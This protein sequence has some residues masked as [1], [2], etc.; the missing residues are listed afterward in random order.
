MSVLE[1][2]AVRYQYINPYVTVEAVKSAD[3]R[4]ERG[5]LYTLQGPSGS[6]KTTLLSLMGGLDLP[7]GGEVLFE[8]QPTQKMKLD[9][10]R[11]EHVSLIYQSYNLLP[12]LTVLENVMYPMELMKV[13]RKTA[14]K[15][16]LAALEQVGLTENEGARFPNMLS[17][18]QQ[19]R[20]AIA[21]ALC[22]KAQVILA[23]EPTGSLD[24]ENGRK[25]MELLSKLA[26]EKGHCVI[27]VTHDDSMAEWADIR[28]AIKDG[29]L[30]GSGG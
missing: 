1:L 20:V 2:K 18:G 30:C 21:R 23:D 16:A 10:Y 17:G 15:E 13:K 3:F 22:A 7:T 29:V 25:V 4:F 24:E 27:V 26:H 9:R 6:G 28:L 19:Q 11:R 8:G 5:R 14:I 12:M